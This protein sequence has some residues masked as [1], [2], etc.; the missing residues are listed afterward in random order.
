MK[1]YT[2]AYSVFNLGT[3]QGSSV[4]EAINSFEKVAGVKLNYKI[5]PRRAGDVVQIYANCDKATKILGWKTERDLDNCMLTS[6]IWE[7]HLAGK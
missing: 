6:W 2:D 3:G 4:L 1:N 5:G 7:K